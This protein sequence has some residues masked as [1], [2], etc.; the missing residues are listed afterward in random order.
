[1]TR[2][3][4]TLVRDIEARVRRDARFADVLGEL[5]EAPT[6]PHGA[7]RRSVAHA[8]NEQRRAAAVQEF[9]A[10]ALSTAQ[11]Q[12]RLGYATP[13]AVH[14]LRS[15][16]RLL[17]ATVGNQTWF[18]AWQFDDTG[19]RPELPRILELL[20]RFTADAVAADRI[21]RLSRDDLDGLSVAEA[22]DRPETAP[23]ARRALTALGA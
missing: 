10:G 3:V 6:E 12:A 16:G 1:M 9:I 2:A 8:L 23:A 18:P 13:Q 11:V 22:L 17:G 15:R 21:M 19:L 7:L 20:T 4:A 14:R 5:L